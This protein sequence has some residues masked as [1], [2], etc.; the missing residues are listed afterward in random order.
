MTTTTPAALDPTA[1]MT[2]P[3]TAT[4]ARLT[5]P[6]ADAI[7]L[8]G[9][10]LQKGLALRNLR[11]KHPEDLDRARS[12][13]LDWTAVATDLLNRLFDNPSVA[14]FCNDWVGKIFPEYAEFG[15][16]VEQ[17]YE[18][19]QQRTTR[20]QSVFDQLNAI[21]ERSQIPSSTAPAAPAPAHA[22]APYHAAP[23]PAPVA[24]AAPHM[25]NHA[26]QN[27]PQRG[28]AP[29]APAAAPGGN[30]TFAKSAPVPARHVKAVLATDGHPTPYADAV[31]KFLEQLGVLVVKVSATT[32]L[33]DALT[34]E[35]DAAFV[36]LLFDAGA[37]QGDAPPRDDRGLLF[38]LGYCAGR[39]GAQRVCVLHPAGRAPLEG[40]GPIEHL[41]LDSTGGWQ[42]QLAR[43]MKR[44]GIDVDLN[45][46]C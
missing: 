36:A 33:V 27:A 24:H 41:G 19:M 43:L 2:T 13:K 45:K 20:L 39:V 1:I 16:F 15:N 10:H 17:F 6:R 11:I 7:Q 14:D 30:V 9:A 4:A 40:V 23:P 18:E 31:A 22:P 34:K 28:G 32:S 25:A 12:M 26:P 37:G 46:L 29:V 8:L 42:L 44:C 38:E 35:A 3:M 5:V 21:A